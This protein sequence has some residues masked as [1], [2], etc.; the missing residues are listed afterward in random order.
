MATDITDRLCYFLVDKKNVC[1]EINGPKL[2]C[3]NQ[4]WFVDL[5]L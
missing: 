4:F 5:D 2:A 3:W 1:L